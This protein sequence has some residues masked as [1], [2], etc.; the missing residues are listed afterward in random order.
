MS[1]S[2]FSSVYGEEQLSIFLEKNKKSRYLKRE[3]GLHVTGTLNVL[4]F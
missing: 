3:G 2:I 4:F 1:L